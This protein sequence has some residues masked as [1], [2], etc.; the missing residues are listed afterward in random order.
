MEEENEENYSSVIS[1]SMNSTIFRFLGK[2]IINFNNFIQGYCQ[3][4]V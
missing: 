1:N 2:F 3:L 4:Q